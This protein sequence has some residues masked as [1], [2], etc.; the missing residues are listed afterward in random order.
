MIFRVFFAAFVAVAIGH[1]SAAEQSLQVLF[2]GDKGPHRPAD[3]AS[4]LIP[5]LAGRGIDVTYTED[6]GVL[7]EDF[8]SRFDAVI[9]Y[10]NIDRGDPE[11]AK[12]LVRYVE[13]GGGFVPIHCASFC[14]QNSPEF[15]ALVGGQ[16]KSHGTGEFET[17]IVAPEHPIMDGLQPF[18]TWDETYV[19]QKHNEDNRTV[20]Q[21]RAEGGQ[22][23]PWTW[24][25]RQ[26][27]GRVFYTAYGHDERTWIQPGFQAL[28]ERGVRWAAN[29]GEVFD[30]NL[31]P[32][33]GLKP[34]EYA[35]ALLPNYVDSDKW[36]VLGEPIRTMQ[37]PVDPEESQKHLVVPPGFKAELFAAEPD[38]VKPVAMN[39]DEKGRLW[40]A[41]T[42]DYPNDL[43]PEGEGNDRIKICEDTNGDGKADKFTIFAEKLSI[44]TSLTFAYGGVVVH[45]APDTLFLKDTDGDGKADLREVLFTGWKT[46]DTHAGPSNLH[47][48]FDGWYY[49]MVGYA[50]FEG[51]V[52]GE[53][54]QF[55]QG[56]YRFKLEPPSSE[57]G[58]PEVSAL[59]FLRSVN[60]NAWGVG[61]S[62]EGL[63]FG[64]TANGCPS[65]FMAIP[66]RYY[67]SV[68][69]WSPSVL[70]S[71][72]P[73]NRY[74]P[75]TDKVRQVDWHGGF[76][77]AAGHELYTARTYP[78]QY[79]N[80]TAFV[81]DPTG[82]LTATFVLEPKGT[83][84]VAYNSW[85][86]VA[87]DDEWTAPIVAQVGPDGHV[88][89]IDWYNYVVQHNPTPQG[90]ET[91]KGNAYV[92]PLR[93]KRHGRIYRILYTG[94]SEDSIP[95]LDPQDSEL[96][97][98]SLGDDNLSWRLHAQRLLVEKGKDDDVVEKLAEL[99][100]GE[101][102]DAIGLNAGATQAIWTLHGLGAL[103]NAAVRDAVAAAL[104]HPSAATRR[105]AASVLPR[106]P[107]AVKTLVE[108]GVLTDRDPQ[109]RLAATLALAEMKQTPEAAEATAN[110]LSDP[111]YLSDRWLRDA[112]TAAAATNAEAFLIAAARGKDLDREAATIVARVGE[113]YGRSGNFEK[114]DQILVAAS[115]NPGLAEAILTGLS[116][117]MTEKGNIQLT[118]E[119]EAAL[120]N[121]FPQLSAEGQSRLVRLTSLWGSKGFEKYA[122]ELAES[123]REIVGDDSKSDEERIAAARRLIEFRRSS[124]EAVSDLL[125]EFS[126]R[127]A[128]RVADGIIAAIGRS[129]ASEAGSAIVER[130]SSMTPAV[131]QGA[132]GVLLSRPEWTLSLIRGVEEGGVQLS[133]LSLD[134]R[135]SLANHPNRGIAE[136]AK[137]LL[138][139]G[140][141]L[142]SADR[143]KVIEELLPLVLE[144][145]DV[146]KGKLI[147]TQQ[148]A[149][150]HKHSGEGSD[151]G[152]DLT[153]MAAHTREELLVHILDPSRSVEGNFRQYTAVTSDG[154]VLNGLL[155]SETRTSVE[156]IDAEG[157]KHS[158]L[159]DELEELAASSKSVMPE[160]FEKQV[161]PEGV[162]DL[163]AF[164]TQRGKYMPLDL[165]K[166]ATITSVEGMFTSKRSDAERLIFSDWS[167]KE[168]NGVPFRLIDPQDGRVP[169]V[170]LLYGPNGQFPP[171]MPKAVRLPVHS[172]AAA[173][174]LL[175]GVAGWAS[176]YGEQGSVSMIVR[177][178]YED[179][180][181]EDHELRNGVEFA[182]YIRVV[183]VPGSELAFR[184]RGQ[185][186][187][188]LAVR[189]GQDKEIA[190]IEFVKGPDDT[191]PVVMGV[192][193]E[194]AQ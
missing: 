190:E 1:A 15:I 84:F 68:R 132:I 19:H 24:V 8:L 12:S 141:G 28:I 44:P 6:L 11:R 77:S 144:G 151:I 163:L 127:L 22:E 27:E 173:I 177:L 42:F 20:L 4:Q 46:N 88:W 137:E 40:I 108:S 114:L 25:R 175:S 119:T 181:T 96:L 43:Q 59:E 178:H 158:L 61:F 176:P 79:W 5:V 57:D 45:Q 105:A 38:I 187:R 72:S 14:F 146:A 10:A 145:G 35:E 31:K 104:K 149:K 106:D 192:T 81:S 138:A 150:C 32:N 103:D 156:I 26:G 9:L 179:G 166:A 91:G 100:R 7:D 117:G 194:N 124:G 58:A 76:T 17:K 75:I 111:S 65:V 71:I 152:P 37:L 33:T 155:S 133:D 23:E 93:D 191:S 60:N 64:S 130:F 185:Q 116:T 34:F 169:N 168:V 98:K 160:G 123:F 140:G 110:L 89:V 48:G 112:T 139:R 134:Q 67:E 80:K 171:R 118:A 50:G 63:L 142:P 2:L 120:A 51:S 86:L 131:R 73:S 78:E 99:M 170:V 162:K 122:A 90:F 36:G 186:I 109:V 92:T 172:R 183:D 147:F 70:P 165:R 82:H 30:S 13:G 113:H 39:W 74:F 154:L 18:R 148:C 56:F 126:P 53:R 41:E 3:R 83:D 182:D 16:F 55:R 69:G 188:Y 180:T 97:V 174:H 129:D 136:K 193:V 107:Q 54:H 153:G 94:A 102:L 184:L 21:I 125:R 52:G 29:E 62:E 115:K 157:K 189:P 49:G 161:P 87:S 135:Q 159:R 143:Q 164:M 128:P 101:E 121:L 66:N 167:P 95:K 85:N 47:Y